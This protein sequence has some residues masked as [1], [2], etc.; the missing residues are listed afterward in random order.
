MHKGNKLVRQ[1]K[2]N[3]EIYGKRVSLIYSRRITLTFSTCRL[4]SP[5]LEYFYSA[6]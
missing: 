5:L 3:V 6:S 2:Y 1:I 4:E